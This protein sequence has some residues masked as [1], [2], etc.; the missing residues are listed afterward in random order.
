M[1]RE[2]F[3]KARSECLSERTLPAGFESMPNL[4]ALHSAMICASFAHV[5]K[6]LKD[7]VV[8]SSSSCCCSVEPSQLSKSMAWSHPMIPSTANM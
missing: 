1:A 2:A 8:R 3:L 4:L 7:R 5:A 6:I